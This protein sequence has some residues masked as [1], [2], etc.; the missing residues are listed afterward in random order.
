MIVSLAWRHPSWSWGCAECSTPRC[1]ATWQ[2]Q[3]TEKHEY[4]KSTRPGR[5]TGCEWLLGA[6][7][8][9]MRASGARKKIMMVSMLWLQFAWSW[10]GPGTGL[11]QY[12]PARR[13]WNTEIVTLVKVTRPGARMDSWVSVLACFVFRN[14]L[15]CL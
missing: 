2:A 9:V 15:R 11:L 13:A 14:G 12:S 8:V 3:N 1:Y 10:L 6:S 5:E 7:E 4:E